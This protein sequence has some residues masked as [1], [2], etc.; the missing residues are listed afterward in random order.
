MLSSRSLR[1]AGERRKG[2]EDEDERLRQKS[3]AYVPC[4]LRYLVIVVL[5]S[6]SRLLELELTATAHPQARSI[7]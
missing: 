5:T 7:L 2:V 3:P 6:G 4:R 1:E